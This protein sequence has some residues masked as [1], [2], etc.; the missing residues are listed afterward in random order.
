MQQEEK[1]IRSY[2]FT[3]KAWRQ[4]QETLDCGDFWS[5]EADAIYQTLT[6][7]IR[8]VPFREY[9]KRYLYEK[10]GMYRPFASVPLQEYAG[11]VQDAFQESGTPCTFAPGTTKMSQAVR[12]WLT[13]DR[14][15]RETV[16]LLGFGLYM[17]AEDVNAFLTK[18]LHGPVLDRDDPG[19]AICLYCYEH[20]YRFEKYTQLFA[21]YRGM[22]EKVDRSRV[23]ANQPLNRPQSRIIIEEDVRLLQRLL[24]GRTRGEGETPARQA[25][26]DAFRSLYARARDLLAETEE[27]DFVRPRSLERVLSASVPL[28]AYGNL[29]PAVRAAVDAGFA[30]KRFSRQRIHRILAGEQGPSRYDLLTLQFFMSSCRQEKIADR[31]AALKGFADETDA[32]LTGLGFGALYPADPFDAFLILC[33]LT[34][35]PLG[36]YSDVMEEAYSGGGEEPS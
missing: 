15:S 10:T 29:V 26:A 7:R 30:Q 32:M 24:D 13:R 14:V 34:D 22:G 1:L 23:E 27:G 16:L 17:T 33:M 3:L 21:L 11:I 20:G 25:R 31:K 12:N 28:D 19:E 2:S 6:G 4:I 35:D 8:A 9:L 18:A 36:S 5:M